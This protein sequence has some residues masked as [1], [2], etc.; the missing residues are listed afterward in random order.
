[1]VES[2]T[3]RSQKEDSPT[4]VDLLGGDEDTT[5]YRLLGTSALKT[6]R[7]SRHVRYLPICMLSNVE[8]E[9]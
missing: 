6:S 2:S 7:Y 8:V 4:H 5:P 3:A 9:G 1:M